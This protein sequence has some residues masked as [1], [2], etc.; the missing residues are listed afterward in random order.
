MIIIR[1]I[2]ADYPICILRSDGYRYINNIV[3]NK[4]ITIKLDRIGLYYNNFGGDCINIGIINNVEDNSFNANSYIIDF[5]KFAS[6]NL[7]VDKVVVVA[8]D[9]V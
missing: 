9:F 5:G 4:Y 1:N 8:G 2:L 3:E 7:A 6:L